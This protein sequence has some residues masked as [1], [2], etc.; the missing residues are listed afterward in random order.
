MLLQ[1]IADVKPIANVARKIL[2]TIA[3]PV[4]LT[5]RTHH[6]TASI[7]ISF[8][9]ADGSDGSTLLKHADAAMYVVKDQGKNGF[10]FYSRAPSP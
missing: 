3:E 5:G 2:S 10:R 9:P 4:E 1:E 8:Y 7:G 6:V